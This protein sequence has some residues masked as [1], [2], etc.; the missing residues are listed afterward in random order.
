[1]E[2]PG[3]VAP[4]KT[5]VLALRDGSLE[6]QTRVAVGR[7]AWL[8][9]VAPETKSDTNAASTREQDSGKK[10]LKKEQSI[11]PA[12]ELVSSLSVPASRRG[13]KSVIY[14]LV[15][16]GAKVTFLRDFCN[17]HLI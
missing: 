14:T 16:N 13:R 8:L 7:H 4:S 2:H 15:R 11:F 10:N 5:G 17:A 3:T 6:L 12:L 1:M 9:P